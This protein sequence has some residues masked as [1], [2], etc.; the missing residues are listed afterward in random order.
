M[1]SSRGTALV[2][3][4]TVYPFSV[5]YMNW[6]T[7]VGKKFIPLDACSILRVNNGVDIPVVA[8]ANVAHPIMI[9]PIT[10]NDTTLLS[11]VSP[12]FYVCTCL[13]R[14]SYKLLGNFMVIV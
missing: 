14:N 12:P 1:G 9:T 5:T 11:I 7:A 13:Q 3:P 4:A 2:R 10:T 6:A 8:V